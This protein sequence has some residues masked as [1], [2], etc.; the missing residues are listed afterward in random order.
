[1]DSTPFVIAGASSAWV[2]GL[3]GSMHCALMCGP[4]ACATLPQGP[5]RWRGAVAW[6]LGRLVAYTL[7]GLLMG[8]LGLSVGAALS[9]NVQPWLPWVMAAGLVATALDLGKHVRPLPFVSKLSGVLMRAGAKLGPS[10]RSLLMGAATPFLPCGLIYGLFIAAMGTGSAW[11]GAAIMG[12]FALGAVPALAAVQWGTRLAGR[13]PTA[14]L[15][16]RRVVPLTAA[17]LLIWRAVEVAN[18][19]AQ[20]HGG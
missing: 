3:T 2:A 6:Q 7:V 17:F 4:L 9:V 16:L 15:T 11:G 5:A 10:G 13:W 19:A 14:A 1:M 20:C 8:M 18:Q 12:A